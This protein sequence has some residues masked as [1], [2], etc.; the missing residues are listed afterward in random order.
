MVA[1]LGCDES[2]RK[3]SIGSSRAAGIAALISRREEMPWKV[4]ET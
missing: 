4:Q 2:S 1:T 3:R